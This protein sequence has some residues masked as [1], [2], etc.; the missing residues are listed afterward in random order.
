MADGL[1]W[2]DHPGV[3]RRPVLVAGFEGWNDAADAS[4][5][6][7]TWLTQ[8]SADDEPHRDD[9]REEHFDFQARRPQVELLG[10]VT[11][12]VTWPENTFFSV[13]R[14]D[15]DLVVLRGIEPSYRWRSFCRAVLDV[16]RETGCEMVVT[17][18][19]APRRRP[20]HPNRPRHR[21]FDRHRA[22]RPPRARVVTVRGPDRHRRRAARC[23]PRR[24]VPVGLA[25]GTRSPLSRRATEPARDARAARATLGPVRA[26]TS[27]SADSSARRP[28]GAR[29][30]TRSR[31]P[32]TT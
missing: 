13:Q 12:T 15:R 6:A 5:A 28:R 10:G 14:D 11:R 22:G 26:S 8:H 17:L 21:R 24:V 30:S 4:S 23:L 29:R 9:R 31:P 3:L 20:A 1:L 27:T 19:R 32:T 18:G 2:E 25:L 7:A 16:A